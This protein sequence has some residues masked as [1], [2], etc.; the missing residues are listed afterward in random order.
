MKKSFIILIIMFL[1]LN[2]KSQNVGQ[3]GDTKINYTDINGKKQGK[4]EKKYKNSN[5]AYTAFF[6]NDIP[7]GEYKRYY[8]T[9]KLQLEVTYN[10]K[11]EGFA[12]LYWDDS[13]KMAEGKYI[14]TNVKDSTWL[15]YDTQETLISQ[16]TYK[17]GIKDGKE[18]TYFKTGQK[19]E[20]IGWKNGIKHGE[21]NYY[22]D[23]GKP[24]MKTTNING[25]KHGSFIFYHINGLPYIVGTYK[26]GFREG[27]WNFY[28]KDNQLEKTITYQK[29]TPINEYEL[30]VETE[31]Q[32]QEWE[33]MEGKIPEPTY[34]NLIEGNIKQ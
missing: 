2:I 8:A 30:D 32:I 31:K 7:I 24:R 13:K 5:I 27:K 21:W 22:Y 6:I 15:F 33:K 1:T 9:G 17:N 12:K 3:K 14:N 20:E 26:N 18:I 10:K 4:W 23:F 29:G 16:I 25:K 19:N 11:S 28:Y 34:E